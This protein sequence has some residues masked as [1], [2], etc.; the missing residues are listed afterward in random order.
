MIRENRPA[1]VVC[2]R[3]TPAPVPCPCGT[4]RR[5][6]LPYQ[7]PRLEALGPWKALTLQQTV[8]IGPGAFLVD[9]EAVT[10]LG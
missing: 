10:G 2:P 9:P 8:P 5:G 4:E 1:G 6:R 3:A 7:A